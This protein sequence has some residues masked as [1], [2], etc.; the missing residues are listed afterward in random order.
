MKT[1]SLLRIILFVMIAGLLSLSCSPTG[2]SNVI[3]HINLG[4]NNQNAFNAPESSIIDRVLRFFAKEAKAAPS[5]INSLELNVFGPGVELHQSYAS[6]DIPDS[7][8]LEVPSGPSRLFEVI[9]HV[10]PGDPSVVLSYRGTAVCNLAGGETVTIPISMK[11]NETKIVIPDWY[12]SRLIQIDDMNGTNWLSRTSISGLTSQVRPYDI[13][14]DNTGKIYI[15]NNRGGSGMGDNSV[16]SIDNFNNNTPYFYPSASVRGSAPFYDNGVVAIAVDRKNNFIY[17]A[18]DPFSGP[19][20]FRAVFGDN[21]TH[22]QLT[23]TGIDGIKGM[24]VD[25]NG[26]LYIAGDASTI[27]TIFKYNPTDQQVIGT[28]ATDLLLCWDV[29]VKDGFL[30]VA[31]YDKISPYDSSKI[32]QLSLNLN[33]I[34]QLGAAGSGTFHGPH[35]F[36]AI[37]NNRFCLLDEDEDTTSEVERIVAFDNLISPIIAFDPSMVGQSPFGFYSN[38]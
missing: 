22:T 5:N 23:I 4:L 30:Y 9:A 28:Y 27:P 20:L 2:T 18:L 12:N 6:P 17:Y 32:V 16:I 31:D 35:R 11:I 33:Y 37:L 25:E 1:N 29:L 34:T 38:S 21:M 10:A 3:I 19:Y 36:L 8:T 14:F 24:A 26:I 7:V 15:A 13:D